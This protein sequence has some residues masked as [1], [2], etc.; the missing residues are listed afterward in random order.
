MSA[1]F[2]TG[3]GIHRLTRGKYQTLATAVSPKVTTEAGTEI[4]PN[5]RPRKPLTHGGVHLLLYPTF[6]SWIAKT[7]TARLQFRSIKDRARFFVQLAAIPFSDPQSEYFKEAFSY[8]YG[9]APDLTCSALLLLRRRSKV[10]DAKTRLA[11]CGFAETVGTAVLS[12]DYTAKEADV[13]R[14]IRNAHRRF[15]SDTGSDAIK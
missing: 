3:P 10:I 8:C 7:P 9:I 12:P 6:A 11:A 4:K 5:G 2:P 15:M 13:R 1:G 14:K